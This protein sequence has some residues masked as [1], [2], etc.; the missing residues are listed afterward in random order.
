MPTLLELCGVDI[1]EEVQGISYLP[2]LDGSANET[3]DFVA[4]QTFKM[5]DGV[6]GEFTPVPERGIRTKAWLYVRQPKRRKLLF[7]QIADPDELINLVD[8]PKYSQLM[9]QFDA[10]IDAHM[11]ATGDKWE[12]H[13]D[14]PPPD[15]LTHEEG[16][17]Y[18]DDVLMP[19]AIVVN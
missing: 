1:P 18:I 4:Y 17:R 16:K 10:Q 9:D 12:M 15:F 19:S 14:F 8:D 13:A 6:K 2:L 11:Q 7:D 3:R 5:V